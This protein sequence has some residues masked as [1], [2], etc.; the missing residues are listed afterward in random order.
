MKPE[1]PCPKFADMSRQEK[2]EKENNKNKTKGK[3]EE[4]KGNEDAKTDERIE[5]ANAILEGCTQKA[6]VV[7]SSESKC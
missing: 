5:V 1:L 7:N 4:E 2:K 6:P 3:E